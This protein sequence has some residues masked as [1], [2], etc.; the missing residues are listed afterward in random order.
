MDCLTRFMRCQT[1]IFVRET[2]AIQRLFRPLVP[3]HFGTEAEGLPLGKLM[4]WNLIHGLFFT[5]HVSF[6]RGFL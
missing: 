2:R 3:R 6:P 1:K 4:V 5:G